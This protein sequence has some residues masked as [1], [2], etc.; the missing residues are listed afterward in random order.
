MIAGSFLAMTVITFGSLRHIHKHSKSIERIGIKTDWRMMKAYLI[1]W[2]GTDFFCL[3]DTVLFAMVKFDMRNE[4]Q[5]S[6]Q[7]SAY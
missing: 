4:T 6:K 1:A 3:V 5:N 7:L 2:L